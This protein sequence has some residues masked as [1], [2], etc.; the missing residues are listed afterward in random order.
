MYTRIQFEYRPRKSIGLI[1][2]LA[3]LKVPE[4]TK[5][6]V[7]KLV[8]LADKLHLVRYARPITG[9]WYAAMPHGPV[10]SHTDNLLD[11]FEANVR[12]PEVDLLSTYVY[13]DRKFQYPRLISLGQSQIPQQEL[14]ASDISVLQEAVAQYGRKTF[15]EL[16]ALTHE[17]P[18]YERA[19]EARTG[20]RGEIRFEDLFEEDENAIAG[21]MDE[22]LENCRLQQAFPEPVWD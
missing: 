1:C 22:A 8:F 14:S 21:V 2:L 6:K 9:D 4:L 7:N 11:A 20:N 16:R 15:L 3:E 5:G 10:P 17:M 18:A 19:W 13:L 12:S